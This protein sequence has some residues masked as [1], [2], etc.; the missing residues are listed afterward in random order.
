MPFTLAHPAAVLPLRNLGLPLSAM[1]V[2]AM[3]PDLPAM[4]SIPGTRPWTHSLLAAVTVDL[5]M[6]LAALLLWYVVLRRPLVDLAPDPWR[7]RLPDR[8]SMSART[9][10]LCVPAVAVG[11]LTHV[12]W[13]AFTHDDTWVTDRLGLLTDDVLGVHVYHWLQHG[14]TVLGLAVVAVALR[15]YLLALPDLP[16]KGRPLV[17]RWALVVALC[18]GALLGMG[19]AV[20]VTPWGLEAMAYYGVVTSM[21][22]AGF[23]ATC[24]CVW[25]H[26]KRVTRQVV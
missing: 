16:P 14:F 24:V 21:L 15:R 4:M 12:V 13:D 11:A 25:W 9:R 18:S 3:V 20:L 6:G 26:V 17:G 5:A 23:G 19:I 22:V 10:L 1:V 7:G 2:G 8:V